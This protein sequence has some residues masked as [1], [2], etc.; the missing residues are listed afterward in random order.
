M[1]LQVTNHIETLVCKMSCL[2]SRSA[3]YTS[4]LLVLL[5]CLENRRY[6]FLQLFVHSSI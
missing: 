4:A 6:G 3:V 5:R 2:V 1:E